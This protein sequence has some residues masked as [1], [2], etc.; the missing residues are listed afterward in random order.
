MD[1]RGHLLVGSLLLGA[2]RIAGGGAA[3]PAPPPLPQGDVGLAARYPE[4]L[5][6]DRDPAVLVYDDFESAVPGRFGRAWCES[7]G[8]PD[9]L[10]VAT[11]ADEVHRGARSMAM[12]LPRH[13]LGGEGCGIAKRLSPGHDVLFLRYYAK[14]GKDTELFHGGAHNGGG[15]EA[16]SAGMVRASAGTR[17]DGRSK[18]QI[19]LDTWRSNERTPSPGDL[20]V[21][22]YHPEQAHRWGEQ[23]FPNGNSLPGGKRGRAKFGPHFVARKNFIPERGRW[24]CYELMVK[25]NTPGVRDGRIA[26]WVDGTLVADFPGLRL[27]DV[28]E[29]KLSRVGLGLYT[30]NE[31]V[32]KTIAMSYDDVVVATSYIGPKFTREKARAAAARKRPRPAARP[33]PKPHAPRI[34]AEALAPWEAKLIARVRACV[35]EGARPA[36]HLNQPGTGSR[37]S[38]VLAADENSLSVKTGGLSVSLPWRALSARERMG[39][40][41]AVLREKNCDD[42][43]L[44]A[45]LSLAAGSADLAEEHFD[46]ARSADPER[47]AERV[48]AARRSLGL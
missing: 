3:A 14:F 32:Q 17:A 42:H 27:R 43:I 5:G 38:T 46:S 45:V 22:V 40:A 21:Y 11:T 25:A 15:L 31:R 33:K 18:Y 29:L 36:I 48:A 47:G 6:I 34:A 9:L 23:F 10:R 39:L 41:R 2:A 19:N 44:A 8:G 30:Q 35:E 20:V 16:L 1:A 26:F 13:R 37:P 4:D 24:Y 12:T 28:E 7:W